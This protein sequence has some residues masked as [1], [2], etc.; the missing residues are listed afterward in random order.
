MANTLK[1]KRSA[2]DGSAAPGSGAL[3]AGELSIAQGS[4][5]L[6]IGREHTNLGAVE[7][8]HL[9][10][11]TDLT[12]NSTS[13]GLAVASGDAN[14]N[15]YT[16][17]LASGVAGDGLTLSSHV[18]NVSVDSAQIANGSIDFAHMSA[19][20]ID[21]DQY[22]DGSID[23]VH[24]AGSIANAK[25]ANS[26]TTVAGDS[27]S[28]AV[29][30]GGTLTIAGTANEIVTSESGGTL[31]I[32]LPDNVTIGGNLTV[33]GTTTTVNSTTVT[34]DDTIFTLGGDGA[35]G[36]DDNKDRGIEFK[37]HNGSA[38][39]VGFFGMDDSDSKFKFIPDGAVTTEVSSGAVG[40][41]E[42]NDVEAATI[43]G[44]TIDCGSF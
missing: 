9:P 17:T 42:W 36:S 19:N 21:S 1:I 6:Y 26:S 4:K 44:A 15:A 43:S 31:T 28:S 23:N 38:A 5:K 24:L 33:D 13:F 29:S 14:N 34:I 11:L 10:L 41:S 40:S 32:A 7:E 30:L 2:Y 39:K 37:W 22:V 16:L 25:L 8:Y 12:A 27:G 35:A 20:S 18:L 3:V